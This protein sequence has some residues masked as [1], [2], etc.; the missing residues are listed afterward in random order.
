MA[1]TVSLIL[2]AAIIAV[3]A[4]V[5]AWDVYSI[6]ALPGNLTVSAIVYAWGQQF[7]PLV[8]IIGL[9]LGHLFWPVHPSS[10]STPKGP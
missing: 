4:C 3:L 5:G 8:L 2:A 6:F 1:N 7:P 9:I 10:I